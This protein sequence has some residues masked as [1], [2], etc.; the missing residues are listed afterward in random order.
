MTPYMFSIR[1]F[2]MFLPG[3][4]FPF[5]PPQFFQPTGVQPGM[6]FPLSWPGGSPPFYNPFQQPFAQPLEAPHPSPESPRTPA[7]DSP[8]PT[9]NPPGVP[10]EQPPR[11]AAPP[12]PN[13]GLNPSATSWTP[14]NSRA[15][16][17]LTPPRPLQT[18]QHRPPQYQSNFNQALQATGDFYPRQRERPFY[19]PP[20]ARGQRPPLAP[21]WPAYQQPP[22]FNPYSRFQGA[23]RPHLSAAAPPFIANQQPPRGRVPGSNQRPPLAP[24]GPQPFTPRP[25]TVWSQRPQNPPPPPVAVPRLAPKVD[26]TKLRTMSRELQSG[27]QVR[28]TKG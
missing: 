23:H 12:P 21:Q 1:L 25:Q 27:L 11:A 5:L 17:L 14:P 3:F 16:P 28:R 24:R 26:H 8:S 2:Q 13:P 15:S 19:P 22:P 10:F 18:P 7:A 9:A 4:Q 6:G 20:P